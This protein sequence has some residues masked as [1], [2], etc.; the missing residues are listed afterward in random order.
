[1][2]R[3]KIFIIYKA[4]KLSV[5]PLIKCFQVFMMPKFVIISTK[6]TVDLL[7]KC[8]P[9]YPKSKFMFVCGEQECF[10]T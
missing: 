3:K 5:D 10:S 4:I 2:H 7:M 1:M 8:Y 9:K 6:N